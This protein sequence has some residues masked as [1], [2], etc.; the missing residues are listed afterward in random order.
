MKFWACLAWRPFKSP[1]P[2]RS[3]CKQGHSSV[4]PMP[5]NRGIIGRSENPHIVKFIPYSDYYWVGG[6]AYQCILKVYVEALPFMETL[7]F[8]SEF[9][10][11]R[12]ATAAGGSPDT[13]H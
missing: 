12:G 13:L 2:G 6:Y 5:C 11:F 3:P 10:C 7:V 1:T 8:V 4:D 9:W